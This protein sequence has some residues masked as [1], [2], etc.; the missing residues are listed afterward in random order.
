MTSEAIHR[1]GFGVP[2]RSKSPSPRWFPIQ[3][4]ESEDF[5]AAVRN[6]TA[7]PTVHGKPAYAL[8]MHLDHESER[9]L[10]AAAR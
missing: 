8:R 9:S 4:G 5:V 7:F 3:S 10:Q 1:F 6:L 2:E